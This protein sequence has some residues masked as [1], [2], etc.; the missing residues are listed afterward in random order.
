MLIVH[1]SSQ[2]GNKTNQQPRRQQDEPAAKEATKQSHLANGVDSQPVAGTRDAMMLLHS[3]CQTYLF[4]ANLVHELEALQ[5]LLDANANVL[6]RQGAGPEAVVKVEEALVRLHTQE[7]C[8][9]LVVGK[10][11]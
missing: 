11:G 10:S 1:I 4:V 3:K 2:G 6:L 9:I 7:G 5:R 8:H